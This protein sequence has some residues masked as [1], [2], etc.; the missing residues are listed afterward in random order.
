MEILRIREK[1]MFMVLR[2]YFQLT[3]KGIISHPPIERALDG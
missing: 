3:V 2:L 1:T